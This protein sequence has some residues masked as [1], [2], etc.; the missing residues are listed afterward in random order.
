MKVLFAIAEADP[1]IKTGGLGDVGGSL[2]RAINKQ[3]GL[4]RVIMPKYS[5]IPQSFLKEMRYVISFNVDLAW[6]RQYCGLWELIYEGVHYYFIDNEYYFK[7]AGIYGY[8]D[9]GER[10]AFF[11]KAVL[12][13][14]IRMSDFRPDI[15]HCNDWH[16]ALIPMMLKEY[17]SSNPFY[18]GMKTIF[19]IHNLHHQGIFA[20]EIL[21]DVLSLS[22]DSNGA[23]NLEFHEAANYLK[24][25]LL[26]S[27]LITTVSPTYSEEILDPYYGEGL[28]AFLRQRKEDLCGILNGIDYEKYDPCLDPALVCHAP[29]AHWKK[30]NKLHV[31]MLFN[32]PINDQVPVLAIIS[33]LVEQKGLDLL[34]HIIR[35]L[36][37]LDLQIV[38]LG[39]GDYKN[40]E[41]F[42]YFAARYPEKLGIKFL[43]HEEWAHKIYAGADML[44]MPSRFEPCGLSQMTAMRYGTIPIV[45]E[46]GGL[47]D[48]V[49]PYDGKKDT[50]NGFTFG[51][52]NAHELLYT[53]QKA[54]KLYHEDQVAWQGLVHRAMETDFSWDLSAQKYLEMYGA[55]M[56][57][58]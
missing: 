52:Y 38:V 44:L 13:S 35:E 4:L 14:L 56:V 46:T 20:K 58:M 32:L 24:G 1:F 54:V 12:E 21:Q 29:E 5:S 47:K 22:P 23:R 28:D 16:T 30:E 9:D 57:K 50:G 17:Y 34:S 15:I 11:N 55:L 37:E 33:R 49:I 26:Y 10:F 36:M 48:S 39:T 8:D 51:P 6:R 42:R 40:E 18:Y 41:T 19:T 7:R 25:A 45:R 2:P 27:D 53:V 3:N 31:Q 43:F